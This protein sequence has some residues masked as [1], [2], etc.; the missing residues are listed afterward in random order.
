MKG[1]FHKIFSGVNG[2]AC[3]VDSDGETTALR[4][5]NGENAKYDYLKD[6]THLLDGYGLSVEIVVGCAGNNKFALF[7]EDT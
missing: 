5:R 3:I 4:E 1:T 6:K 7:E 2:E